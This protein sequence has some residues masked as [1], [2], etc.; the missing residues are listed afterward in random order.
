MVEGAELV[1]ETIEDNSAVAAPLSRSLYSVSIPHADVQVA[2][3]ARGGEISMRYVNPPLIRV[4]AFFLATVIGGLR[5]AAVEA[6]TS[7]PATAQVTFSKD[8][9]PIFQRSCQTC[10][11]PGQVAPMS[12]MTYQD[13]RPWA[14]SIKTRVAARSM[15]PWHIDKTVGIQKFKDDFS[16]TDAEVATVVKWVDSGA[17]QGDQKDLPPA[18]EFDDGSRWHIGQPDLIVSSKPTIIP[19]A[20]PDLFPNI[21]VESGLTE[22][23]YIKATEVKPSVKGRAAVHHLLTYMLEHVSDADTQAGDTEESGD[24]FLGEY[25]QGKNGDI[26][27]DGSGK[28]L[29]AGSKIKFG[30]HNHSIGEEISE[31]AQ[32]AFVFYPRGYKPPH[33]IYAEPMGGTFGQRIGTDLDIPSGQISRHDGYSRLAL[34]IKITAIQPHMHTRGVRQ[35]IELIYPDDTQEVLNCVNFNFA[36]HTVYNYDEASAPIAPAGTIVHVV[37][38]HDNSV[39]YKAN[40]DPKNWVGVGNRTIDE[41]SFMWVSWYDLTQDEYQQELKARQ[42]RRVAPTNNQ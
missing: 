25:A 22:D 8:V 12:L 16:L 29:K 31:A 39:N 26:F 24:V 42:A 38:W 23:R 2:R 6:Q 37:S 17:A 14:R 9:A 19:K 7:A 27:G 33:L 30:Y 1:V 40:P 10:H 41:M 3:C 4:A 28:L 13:A 35:C 20:G 5:T 15:P 21:V 36:W 18:L 34:P 32:V 11:R